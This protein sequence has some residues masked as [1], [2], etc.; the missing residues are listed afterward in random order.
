MDESRFI[1]KSCFTNF[2]RA[3]HSKDWYLDNF[4]HNC[5]KQKYK[6]IIHK[7]FKS[8]A[9]QP[10]NHWP[11]S[12]HHLTLD[13]QFSLLISIFQVYSSVIYCLPKLAAQLSGVLCLKSSLGSVLH[14]LSFLTHKIPQSVS[15]QTIMHCECY[16]HPQNCSLFSRCTSVGAP[17]CLCIY[18]PCVKKVLPCSNSPSRKLLIFP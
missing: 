5:H 18:C 1:Q 12:G 9:Y 14:K 16:P 10:P 4:Y 11:H 7:F 8:P 6:C 13:C 17:S 2:F 15:S 3:S